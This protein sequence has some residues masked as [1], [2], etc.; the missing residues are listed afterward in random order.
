LATR[1]ARDIHGAGKGAVRLDSI[2]S[3]V[4]LEIAGRS[5]SS[6]D[7]FGTL[8][9]SAEGEDAKHPLAGLLGYE[10]FARYVVRVDF[11]ARTISLYDPAR[12]RYSGAG[13]TVQLQFVRKL[14]RVDVRIT[15]A[16]RPE[17]VHSLIV[18]LGSEDAVDD[19]L[20]RRNP[21]GPTLTVPTT[22]VG[23]S[24]DAVIGMLD[25]VRI[26]RSTFTNVRG[27]ASDVGIV[28]NGI[29]SK[30]ICIFDYPHGRLFLER[31]H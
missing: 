5:V 17:V 22:G 11:T 25:T 3:A 29:W 7:H 10:F 12:Y 28:G 24:Y 8:D 4:R 14:P 9:L 30:F 21:N 18:D 23:Q 2:T 1:G 26:G 31:T 27:V 16:R 13:D 15:T 6:C 19:S 20:I